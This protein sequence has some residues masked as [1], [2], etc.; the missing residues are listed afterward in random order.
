MPFKKL[1]P[2]RYQSPSGKVFNLNQVRL[3]Y[4]GG[5]HF[6]GQPGFKGRIA[7]MARGGVIRQDTYWKNRNCANMQK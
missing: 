2:N 5:D 1:G 7:T 4:A 6:P 3:Y